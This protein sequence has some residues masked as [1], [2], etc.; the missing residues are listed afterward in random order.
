MAGVELTEFPQGLANQLGISLF[1]GQILASTIFLALLLIPTLFV[2]K[3]FNVS[4]I[5]T[6]VMAI[7]GLSCCVAFGWLGY[8]FLVMVVMMIALMFSGQMRNWLSGS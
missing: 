8:W 3:K 6:Y 2:S 7:L 5:A 4:S 1:A